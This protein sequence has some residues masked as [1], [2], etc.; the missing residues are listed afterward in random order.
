[1]AQALL[2]FVILAGNLHASVQS[3]PQLPQLFLT[4]AFG[5]IQTDPPL[6]LSQVEDLLKLG[7]GDENIAREI[8]KR[9]VGFRVDQATLDR[10]GKFGAGEQTRR[11]LLQQEERAAYAEFSNEKNPAKRLDLG[12]EFLRKHSRSSEA[13][14]VT[15]ELRKVEIEIF[16]AAYRSFSDNPSSSGLEQVLTLGREILRRRPDR[17]TVAQITSKL[18]LATGRGMI[19]NFYND[20]EQSRA[21]ADQSLRLLEDTSPP[22]GMDQQSYNQLRANSLS[23]VYQSLGLYQLRQA[24]PNSEQAI[25]YLTKAAELKD[26]AAANDPI[27]YWLRAL[28]RDMNFQRLSDEYRALPKDQRAGRQGQS[29]CSGITALVNQ[30]ILDY[31][32]VVSLSSRAN[33][34]QLKDEAQ[35]AIIKLATGDRPCLSGRGG[36]IDELPS[37]ENRSALVI[38]VEDYLDKQVG[39]FNYAASGARDIADAL[40]RHGG[41]RKEQI[42]VLATGEAGERAPLRSVILQ[43]LA[44]LP[45][46]VKQ[47]GLLLIYFAGH[48]FESAGKNYLLAADSLT[49]NESLL[50]DTA[51]NVEQFKELIRASGAGQI[52]LIFDSFRR[53]PVSETL[54]RQL[55]FDVRKNEVTAFATL[56]SASVGQRAHESPARKQGYF[57]SVFLEAV[58]GKAAGKNRGVTL[59]GLIKY[60]QTAVPREAQRELGADVQQSPSAVFEGYEA[61]DLVMFS[62]DSGGQPRAQ[63]PAE[64]VRNSQ[65]IYV[66][67][68]TV[69]LNPDMLE[70]E[71]SKLPEF[72]ALKLKIVNDEKEADLVVEVTLPFL[73]WMWNY[74]LTH[75]SSARPLASGKLRELTAGA[76]SPKLAK[77][78]V[79][80]LQ[81]LRDAPRR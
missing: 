72:Q 37:E 23:V 40:V 65:T 77:D 81:N 8:R 70:A 64:L 74:T 60:L 1:M 17:A 33:S 71:L 45:N 42:V 51:I 10:L 47:D 53:A 52:V 69:Y 22:P 68:K 66:R 19:G 75:R 44:E 3:V 80:Q 21:Y 57:T 30:L 13:A 55:S 31:T 43:Q 63:E 58:R 78:L 35:E 50:S 14:K 20:L 11:A 26:G 9:G 34:L 29:L 16:D 28:A 79:T 38:G 2:I 36:L 73:T 61:E 54:S 7:L 25:S 5:N 12:Q 32:Q 48:S 59:D 76:A 24:E 18:A 6:N 4:A 56:L 62:P 41:F 39:K 15:A 67:S 49:T 27:T 46:R